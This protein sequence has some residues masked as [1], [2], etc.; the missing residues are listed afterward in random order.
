MLSMQAVNDL[1]TVVNQLDAR[2][3]SH[4]EQIST[5]EL[6][7]MAYQRIKILQLIDDLHAKESYFKD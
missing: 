5:R 4:K 6:E 7:F 1:M 2:I 3:E